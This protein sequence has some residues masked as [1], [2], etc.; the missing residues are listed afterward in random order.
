MPAAFSLNRDL[1]RIG[2]WCKRWELLVNPMK[3]KVL[4]VN[5]KSK[6]F[7]PVFPNLVLDG[8]VDKR[9]IELKALGVVLD[10]KLSFEC[11]IR[12]IAASAS[13]Q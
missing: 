5:F 3:T 4:V 12:S 7:A 8:T 11:H 2:Y 9:V 13:V 6:T 10:A 1:A